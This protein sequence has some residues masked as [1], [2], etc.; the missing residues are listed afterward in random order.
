MGIINSLTAFF[1]LVDFSLIKLDVTNFILTNILPTALLAADTLAPSSGV[2][3]LSEAQSVLL[4]LWHGFLYRL[5]CLL[6][7][8]PSPRDS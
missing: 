6:Y 7:T 2:E 3:N 5:P 1:N 8:S 4:D